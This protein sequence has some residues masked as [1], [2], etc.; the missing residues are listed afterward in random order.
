MSYD[1]EEFG[2]S[3]AAFGVGGDDDLADDDL[4]LDEQLEGLPDFG[5]DEEDPDKDH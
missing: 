2:V 5:L 4:L 1:E 3:Q